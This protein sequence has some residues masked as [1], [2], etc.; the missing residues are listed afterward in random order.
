[1]LREADPESRTLHYLGTKP[2]L[3][4][5]TTQKPRSAHSAASF[6]WPIHPA[7]MHIVAE[8]KLFRPLAGGMAE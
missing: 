8:K 1:M 2:D 6:N 4:L 5:G 3:R 7:H